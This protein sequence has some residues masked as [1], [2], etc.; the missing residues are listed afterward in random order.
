MERLLALWKRKKNL[1]LQGP[2]GV[3]KTF[4]AKRLAYTL[5]GYKDQSRVDMVQFHPS[6]AYEDFIQ[7]YRPGHNG[8]S[9]KNGL[10]YN[11]CKKAS[12]DHA[13]TYVFIIDE[14]NRGNLGKIFGEL[15]MLLESDKR[16]SEWSVPLTYSQSS[17]DQF[18][19]PENLYLLGLMNTA[20]RSLSIVDYALRRR[21]AFETLNP[22]LDTEA[23]R[24][25][26]REHGASSDL[27]E[28][29]A[30]QLRDLNREICEDQD[31]GKGFQIGHSYFCCDREKADS[32]WYRSII[33]SEIIPLLQEY[34][35]EDQVR[36]QQWHARLLAGI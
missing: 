19:V 31:L 25:H 3:G 33:E 20:D 21:F 14:V 12:A 36:V 29:I 2:P 6:Y 28:F 1:I 13:S 27:T 24:S 26:L 10:F 9:L 22:Q 15:M 32:G 17:E 5:I 4:V 16:G 11:F 23:F 30:Q 34:W 35:F 18:Y 8:F 7:G